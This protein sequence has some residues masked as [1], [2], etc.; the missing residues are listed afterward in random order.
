MLSPDALLIG[1]TQSRGWFT[2]K[3]DGVLV[4]V[5]LNQFEGSNVTPCMD[6]LTP[7]AHSVLPDI[8]TPAANT[9][10]TPSVDC[11]LTVLGVR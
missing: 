10:G 1:T 6:T 5:Q 7:G 3:R 9:T 4:A 11:A 2:R 8:H